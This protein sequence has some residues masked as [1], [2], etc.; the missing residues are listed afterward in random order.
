MQLFSFHILDVIYLEL[1]NEL[2]V[3]DVYMSVGFFG[4]RGG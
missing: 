4:G 2:I 1:H 3:V